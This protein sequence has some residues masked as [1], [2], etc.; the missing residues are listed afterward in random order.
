MKKSKILNMLFFT[1]GLQLLA[2]GTQLSTL[3]AQHVWSYEEC[4][5]YA[6]D[7]NIDIQ[8]KVVNID[9]QKNEL[10]NVQNEWLPS[11]TLNA[12]QRFS[13]GN[14]LASTGTMASTTEAFNAD[15][16][17][18]NASVDAELTLFDG[19]RRKNQRRSGHWTVQQAT[20]SL[21]YSRKSLTIQIAT[22]YLQVLYEKGMTDVARAQ[23]ETS[24]QLCEKTKLLVDD[25]RNPKSD[26]AD[27]Q[28]QLAADEYA[29]TEAEGRYKI[30]LLTLSQLLNLETVEGFAI[31]EMADE[32]LLAAPI[33]NP[34][35]SSENAIENFPSIVSG[36]AS[37]EKSRYDI[38]TA[39]SGYYPRIDFR[40]SLNT[41]YLNFFH[42][43]HPDGFSSQMWNNKSEVVG[44][45]LSLP[46]FNRFTTRNNIRKAKM[47]FTQS[48]LALE[49]SRQK[50]RK[51]IDQ[52]YYNA[53]NAQS[54]YF[55]AK[56]SEEASLLS[57]Q[58]EKEKFEAGRSTIYDLTQAYQRL[59]KSRE[60]ALQA[61]YEAIIRK[62]IL[63]VY[64]QQ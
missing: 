64:N 1:A 26:L 48:Q 33:I 11:V 39:R 27:A 47:S 2:L 28:A 42:Q 24:R 44:L 52:A 6:I 63:E 54:K 62:I 14:A 45:H 5:Q 16:S 22:Y 57:S 34:L 18:T 15:L 58:Y 3:H 35:T 61:K 55:S 43:T 49:D 40:A 12:A 10:N 50:L 59:R 13:F 56:K 32:T 53:L 37:V 31:A 25:G 30:A 60:D 8:Q 29:F 51:D 17:Y 19:F 36:K 4:V 41:Y 7:H 46:V 38:A 20:A 23:V 21:D 9:M